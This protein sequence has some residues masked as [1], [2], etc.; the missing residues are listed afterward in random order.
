MTLRSLMQ[1]GPAKA[2]ELFARLFETSGAAVK[3]RERLFTELKGELELHTELEEQHLFPILKKHAE[4]KELVIQAI[5]DN[6]ELRAKLAEVENLPKNQETFV[7]KLFDL[8][9][10]F[11]QHA[12]DDKKELLPAVQRAL[13]DDQVQEIAER[14]E[15]GQAEADQAK[16]DEAEERR[17]NAR[18]EREAELKTQQDEAAER[19]QN[20]AA[21]RTNEAACQGAERVGQTAEAARQ[22]T[23][24]VTE[25]AQRL[26]A[27][28][29]STGLFFWDW[30]LGLPERRQ[31]LSISPSPN[32]GSATTS[33]NGP[34][35]EVIPLAEETLIVGKRT[36]N[37]GTTRIRRY[38][39]ET[40]VEQQVSLF[41]EKVI[42]ER[43]RPVTDAATGDTLTEL[44]IEVIETSEVPVAAKS[45]RVREEIVVRKERTKRI[46]TVRDT[47]RRDEVR[48]EQPSKQLTA[49]QYAPA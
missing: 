16:H 31:E 14:I 33:P 43:R 7:E 1:V 6:K 39:V 2:N 23:R 8:Q 21:R 40:P 34:D 49:R 5:K 47:V 25:G 41:D 27:A 48:V 30:M 9:K 44:S 37:S 24:E 12:R 13:S 35:E 36:V 19:E 46:A 32:G 45:V 20:T 26:A 22:V 17:G 3:T 29:L 28:P 18:R 42:V 38:V 4:T 11:R 15:A 10:T